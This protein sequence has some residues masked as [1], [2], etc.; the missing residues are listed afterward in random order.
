MLTTTNPWKH[1]QLI[2]VLGVMLLLLTACDLLGFGNLPTDLELEV[3]TESNVGAPTLR[4]LDE[5]RQTLERGAEVGPET[6]A[7]IDRLNETLR[8]VNERGIQAEGTIGVDEATLQR[9]DTLL[10]IIEEDL[11]IQ[12]NLGLDASTV[13]TVNR[14]ADSIDAAPGNWEAAATEIIQTL[15]R[16]TTTVGREMAV[17]IKGILDRAKTNS[18]QLS[19]AIGIETRC[20]VDFMGARA[21]GTI[22]DFIGQSIVGQ[23]RLVLAGEAPPVVAKPAKVCQIIPDQVTLI[24]SGDLVVYN[25]EPL[26]VSGYDLTEANMPEAYLA[27]E[28]GQRI[29]NLPLYP[30]RTS[31]YQLQLNLQGLDFR[32]LPPRAKLVFQWQN[33]SGGTPSRSEL[34]LVLPALPTPTF[35][36]EPVAQLT[37]G[38]QTINVRQGPGTNYDVIGLAEAGA[39][40]VVLGSNGDGTWWQIDYGNG[41]G[42]VFGDLAQ[43]NEIA[44]AVV[45]DIPL[46]PTSTFT[47]VPADTATNTPLPPPE[48]PTNT[49]VP[50]A[51]PSNTPEPPT[52][53]PVPP[54]TATVTP[55]PPTPV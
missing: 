3:T 18:Q 10:G 49:P 31:D 52:A 7:V 12:V 4:R 53:T 11:G 1:R 45:G 33:G 14:L 30:L 34:A 6:R 23:I 25:G 15:E 24:E 50:A 37:I 35:T 48:L 43:R 5:L 26:R 21:N 36:P 27:D 32:L 29:G 54:P 41:V 55:V 8:Q 9:V 40:F 2:A 46:P 42:W 39:T 44:V 20:N 47:P 16:S 17:E 19:A 51:P 28:Q 22:A 13:E 38:A